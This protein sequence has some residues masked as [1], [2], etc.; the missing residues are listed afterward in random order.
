MFVQASHRLPKSKRRVLARG[1]VLFRN[2]R[3]IEFFL[4]GHLVLILDTLQEYRRFL[5]RYL[6]PLMCTF[7]LV[8][9]DL[10]LPSHVAL[11]AA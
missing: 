3:R 4:I 2:S 5:T 11:L 8:A 7:V 9:E 10:K 6:L 1:G